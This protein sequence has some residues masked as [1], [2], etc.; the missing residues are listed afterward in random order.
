MSDRGRSYSPLRRRRHVRS[1]SSD[2]SRSFS[3]SRRR[4]SQVRRR[5]PVEVSPLRFKRS[6]R[7]YSPSPSLRRV[8]LR[9]RSSSLGSPRPALS[10]R[11]QPSHTVTSAT[12]EEDG[13]VHSRHSSPPPASSTHRDVIL[14]AWNVIVRRTLWL[15]HESPDGFVL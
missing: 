15:N 1:S 14:E 4:R 2:R 8:R 6:R 12:L 7:D 13:D 10:P 5:S 3:P 11:M 9:S